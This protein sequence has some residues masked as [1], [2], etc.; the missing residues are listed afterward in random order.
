MFCFKQLG[1]G[2]ENFQRTNIP[3]IAKKYEYILPNIF[4]FIAFEFFCWKFNM[5]LVRNK[6]ALIPLVENNKN[7][8]QTTVL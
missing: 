4:Y 3:C 7:N 2:N 8:T 6:I 1:D 5:F